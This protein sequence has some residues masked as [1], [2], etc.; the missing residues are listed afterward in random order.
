MP[1]DGRNLREDPAD[2]PIRGTVPKPAYQ[3]DRVPCGRGFVAF[4]EDTGGRDGGD[5]WKVEGDK[6]AVR[7]QGRVRELVLER[8]CM[9][10]LMPG[11]Y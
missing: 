2:A 7:K 5:R 10:G 9:P 3:N 8:D 1:A 4:M 11:V 6:K